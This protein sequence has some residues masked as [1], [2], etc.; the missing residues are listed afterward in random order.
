MIS[1]SYSYMV[2][3]IF[4]L[5]S[6]RQAICQDNRAVCQG[7]CHEALRL[8][9]IVKSCEKDELQ[10]LCFPLWPSFEIYCEMWVLACGITGIWEVVKVHFFQ[11]GDQDGQ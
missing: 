10:C 5:V 4:S 8:Q 6:H 11:A 2:R 1:V 7:M 3:R 9:G